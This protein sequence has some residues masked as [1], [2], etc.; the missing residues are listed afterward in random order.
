MSTD[1]SS[2]QR[3][4]RILA[5]DMDNAAEDLAVMRRSMKADAGYAT[6][7]AQE[8]G[9]A[10]G[11]DHYVELTV[12]VSSQLDEAVTEVRAVQGAAEDGASAARAAARVHRRKY[13]E[14]HEI[15]T[16]RK[17]KTPKPGFFAE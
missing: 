1:Y 15:R 8:L 10:D 12:E 6:I 16:A 11:S 9:E 2:V 4:L 14:L 5:K 17:G 3:Q 13:S 7:T